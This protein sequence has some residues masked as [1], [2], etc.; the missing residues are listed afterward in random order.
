MTGDARENWA[1]TEP[2]RAVSL[3][4]VR[5]ISVGTF[6]SFGVPRPCRGWCDRAGVLT[7]YVSERNSH[8]LP[9]ASGP[10]RLDLHFSRRLRGNA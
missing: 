3:T 7:S 4:F 6:V 9:L 2:P 5:W 10:V 1:Q 8:A